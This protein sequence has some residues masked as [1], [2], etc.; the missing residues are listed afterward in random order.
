M[1]RTYSRNPVLVPGTPTSSGILDPFVISQIP[2]LSN[3]KWQI[4][5]FVFKIDVTLF[6]KL[7][8]RDINRF[9]IITREAWLSLSIHLLRHT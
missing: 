8:N 7:L 3:S 2:L 5:G 9:Y 1:F 6:E 4:F